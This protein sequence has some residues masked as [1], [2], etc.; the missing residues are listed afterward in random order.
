MKKTIHRSAIAIA[1]LGAN[2]ALAGGLWLNEYGDFAGG[3]ATAGAAAG[4][5]EASTVIHNPAS[6]GRLND[7]TLF[8]SGGVLMPT[9]QFEVDE[10]APFIGDGDGGEAGQ[11][12]PGLAAAYV[13]DTGSDKWGLGVSLAGLAGAGLDFNN[14]WVGRYQATEV[15]LLLMAVSPVF[16][17]NVT[18]KLAIGI[19]PQL[20]YAELELDVN[21][22]NIVN[23]GGPD[24]RAELDGDDT[25]FSFLAGITYDFSDSTRMGIRYQSEIDAEF[26]GDLKAKSGNPDFRISR[27][28]E[29]DTELTIAQTVRVALHHELTDAFALDFTIGWDDWAALDNVLVSVEGGGGTGLEK[30]WDDTYH[31]AAGFQYKV[32][33]NWDLTAGIAYDTN[34]VDARDRTAD[35]PVDRQVRYNLGIRRAISDAMTVGGYINYTDLG[36]AKIRTDFWEGEFT[37]NYMYTA[38]VYLDWKL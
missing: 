5:D 6:A 3:R 36:S 28:A 31:Y 18:D 4:T 23:P 26:G 29:S 15:K 13:H 8:V 7:S 20:W 14:D 38:A 25:G 33:D 21:L 17:Y 37:S 1:L 27:V 2:Q 24:I 12:A 9:T 16:S 34:P 22:P 10:S 19:A 11:I 32:D 30:N 35:L